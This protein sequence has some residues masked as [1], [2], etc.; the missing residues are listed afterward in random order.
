LWVFDYFFNTHGSDMQ[1]N[2]WS[3]TINLCIS[4]KFFFYF[5]HYVFILLITSCLFD[6]FR[7]NATRTQ[8]ILTHNTMFSSY[9]L[10]ISYPTNIASI[11]ISAVIDEHR[12]VF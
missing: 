7:C 2:F 11:C 4:F 5:S 8:I 9:R 3:F 12:S 1:E 6:P 10:I